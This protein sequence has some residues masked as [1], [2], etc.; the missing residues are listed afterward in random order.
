[1]YLVALPLL[2]SLNVSL[3]SAYADS[4]QWSPL[5]SRPI[6]ALL[7]RYGGNNRTKRPTLAMLDLIRILCILLLLRVFVLMLPRY[8]IRTY[9]LEHPISVFCTRNL[10][11]THWS[12]L[13]SYLSYGSKEWLRR[14]AHAQN[15]YENAYAH[16]PRGRPSCKLIL[17]TARSEQKFKSLDSFAWDSPV[18]NS[19]Q[20]KRS[21][22]LKF[23]DGQ[24]R[25]ASCFGVVHMQRM[26]NDRPCWS[27]VP[28]CVFHQLMVCCAIHSSGN[29]YT[30]WYERRPQGHMYPLY[31]WLFSALLIVPSLWVCCVT[32]KTSDVMPAILNAV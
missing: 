22:H 19:I 13:H 16:R 29:N 24:T 30:Q 14:T 11:E 15:R 2:P 31:A 20:I 26:R 1:M 28:S 3:F 4:C 21:V 32:R 8:V 7:L 12:T 25:P 9:F 6:V 27:A 10:K 23:A 18:S 5:S 17:K